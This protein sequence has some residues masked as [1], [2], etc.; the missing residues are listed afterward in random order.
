MNGLCGQRNNKLENPYFQALLKE[1]DIVL[2]TETWTSELSNVEIVGYSCCKAHRKLRKKTARRDSGG[3]IVY[4]KENLT[5]GVEFIRSKNDDLMW[6]KFDKTFFSFDRDVMVCLCYVV[7]QN[8][9]RQNVINFDI[10]DEIQTH[11]AEFESEATNWYVITGDFNARTASNPDFVEHDNDFVH[12]PLPENYSVD[13]V[14]PRK[15]ED[16]TVNEYGRRLLEL[17]ISTGL[18]IVNGRVGQD[19]GHGKFTCETSRGSSVVDYVVSSVELFPHIADFAVH[20]ATPFS[21]HN[22]ISCVLNVNVK[23][24]DQSDLSP[25]GLDRYICRKTKKTKW[26]NCKK[27]AY[28]ESLK[29]DSVKEELDFILV[30]IENDIDGNNVDDCVER[31][32]NV[33]TSVA[34]PL[35][36]RFN[37]T[38]ECTH[39]QYQSQHKVPEWMCEHCH[40]LRYV[41]YTHLNQYRRGKTDDLRRSMVTARNDYTSHIRGCRLRYA[42][43]RTDELVKA[44]LENAKQYWKLLKGPSDHKKTN[45][46]NIQFQEFFENISSRAGDFF[47]ADADVSDYVNDADVNELGVMFEELD[48]PITLNEI[49]CAIKQLKSDKSAGSDNIINEL[50]IHGFSELSVYLEAIFNKLLNTGTFPKRWSE[51]LIVPIHK[52]GSIHAAENYRGITLLSV[53]GKL[54]TRVLNNRLTQWA[55]DYG[56]YAESQ[57]G[58]RSGYSTTDSVFVLHNLISWC[59]RSKKKLYCAFVDYTKAFDYVVRDNLWY[60]LLKVGVRGKMYKVIKNMYG[61]VTS[62]VKGLSQDV[63]SFECILGV[64]Q[65]ESLSPFLFAMYINDLEETMVNRGVRGLSI[66]TLKLFVLF[67]ADDAVIFSDSRTGLQEGLDVLSDYCNRWKLVVNIT[68]TKVV[69]FRAGGQ[70]SR[71]DQWSYN[72]TILEI[73]DHFSYLG[74]C[75]YYTGS[76]ARTQLTLAKQGRKAIFALKKMVKQFVGLDPPILCDLFDKLVLPILTYGCEVW[77]F[78]P[79]EA[80]ERV[81]RDFMRSALRVK[82][83]TLNEFLYGELGRQPLYFTRY[84]RIVKYWFKILQS[85]AR[86]LVYKLYQVQKGCIESNGNIVNWVSLLRDLLF[87]YGFGHVWLQQGVGDINSFMIIFK[88]RLVDCYN[89]TWHATLQDSRKA[90]T[91]RT[92]VHNCIVP[93]VYL[94]SVKNLKH[95]I[96]IVRLRLRNNHLRVETGSWNGPTAVTYCRRFCIFCNQNQLE[97]EYHLVMTCPCYRE[98]RQQYIPRYY[99]LRPSMYKFV[100]LMSTE[101]VNLLNRL[102]NYVYK[103]FAKRRAM[104][105]N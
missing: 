8:S 51:G 64:R 66:D 59:F 93:Q 79:S 18:R 91:Y 9:T 11:I 24:N 55:E 30:D 10:F 43:T 35:F 34:D 42:K 33:L 96:A 105:F 92:F 95:R 73:V 65:G 15:S 86:R 98:L 60:K 103:A 1:H 39:Q 104:T 26:D 27:A 40:S 58:F 21:D 13:G 97:D 80:I 69:V 45:V 77:G 101:N 48:C 25:Y 37:C 41:F 29:T 6:L 19:Q 36:S 2:L 85:P 57:G 87:R 75:M 14:W 32:T 28:V 83:T 38:S 44:R 89:Q 63:D 76:F 99:R 5:A 52:K 102:G 81:H 67:Y 50:L 78:H 72:G 49:Y 7:P 94:K 56:V 53:L 17:C 88:Q 16:K 46:T 54:F 68:K 74:I 62:R 84:C 47:T 61:T 90:I 20:E 70:L 31:F 12:M 100:L 4:V 22:L 23:N 71:L 3:L 82:I